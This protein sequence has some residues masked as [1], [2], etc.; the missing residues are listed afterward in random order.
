MNYNQLTP[1]SIAR[2]A[3][4]VG[5][6]NVFTDSEARGRYSTDETEDLSFLPDVVVTPTNTQQVADVLR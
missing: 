2:L 6:S 1:T 5:A 4:I 3:S